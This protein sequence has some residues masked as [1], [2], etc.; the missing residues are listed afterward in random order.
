MTTERTCRGCG[1]RPEDRARLLRLCF[2]C[3]Q[4]NVDVISARPCLRCGEPLGLHVV[5]YGARSD[6]CEVN[7]EHLRPEVQP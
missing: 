3:D 2:E 6:I 5:G 1:E 7:A 4:Q